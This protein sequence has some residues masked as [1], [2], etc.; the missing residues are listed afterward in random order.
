[1]EALRQVTFQSLG[2]SIKAAGAVEEQR[3]NVISALARGLPEFSP[4]LFRHDGAMVLVGSGPSLPDHLEEIR[5]EQLR[6]RTIVAIKGAHDWLME[7]GIVPDVWV[8][9]DPRD[10]RNGVQRK[11]DQ[12]VYMLASRCD[13]VMFDHLKDCKVLLWHSWSDDENLA[14]LAGRIRV[15]GGTT[16][17]LRAVNLG[18]LLGFSRFVLYG[19]DSCL[20]AD[21]K[22]KRFT[23]EEAPEKAIL[24]MIVG[25]RSFLCN[26]AMAMQASE[27]Q[28][29]Y[30]VIPGV[31]FDVKGDGLI[32][33]IVSERRKKGLPA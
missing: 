9:V 26:G 29:I 10:R 3:A 32:A 24:P 18:Y 20:A 11:N 23:G 13:P 19:F 1:M 5:Q 25:G 22:T 2:D 14:E 15:G 27:F 28:E 31:T 21:G 12:T 17:G 33:C 16:S 6:G 8:C 4:A 7:H 30:K